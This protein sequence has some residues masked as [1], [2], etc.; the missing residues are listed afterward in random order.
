[1]DREGTMHEP[2]RAAGS[3]EN[4]TSTARWPL[5]L[6]LGVCAPLLAAGIAINAMSRV[7][8][9]AP[10]TI[11]PDQVAEAQVVEIRDHQ[12]R[13]VLTGEFRARVDMVGN[14]EKDAALLDRN[15]QKVIGEV[16]LEA[17]A[18]DRRDRRPELEVDIIGLP[19]RETF[20][21]VIDNRVVARFTTDDRGS[22]DRELMEG[23]EPLAIGTDGQ[24]D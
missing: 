24:P 16:E 8:P 2:E 19:P 4:E 3:E 7:E 11:T 14:M 20:T 17:P 13:A 1:M 5:I 6:M 23:E 15:G 18:R 10:L 22:I 12:D 21:V 9:G